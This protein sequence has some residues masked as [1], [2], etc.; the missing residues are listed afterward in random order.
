M[1]KQ[2]LTKREIYTK[3]WLATHP[4]ARRGYGRKASRTSTSR[5]AHL[6][7][8]A[9]MRGRRV[10]ISFSEYKE[11]IAQPCFYCKGPL[12][13]TGHGVDRINSKI[14][15]VTGNVRPC[16]TQ[17]NRSKSDSTENEFREWAL[18][19]FNSWAGKL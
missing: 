15:Y 7:R 11:L 1:A 4:E 6:K 19:L 9:Q 5:F 12:P 16:C 14:G 3:A 18:R 2:D 17:C 10:S 8:K 13:E